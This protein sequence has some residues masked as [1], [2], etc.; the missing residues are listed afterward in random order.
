M[1][2]I[3]PADLITIEEAATALGVSVATLRAWRLAGKGPNAIRPGKRL[4]FIRS[5]VDGYYAQMRNEQN[6][7]TA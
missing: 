6:E 5:E 7:R 4:Q 2:N 3:A 1:E